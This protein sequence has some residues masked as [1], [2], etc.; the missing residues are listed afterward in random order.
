MQNSLIAQK[1]SCD[2]HGTNKHI[3]VF[4]LKACFGVLWGP[5]QKL[6]YLSQSVRVRMFQFA[7]DF[8]MLTEKIKT[9]IKEKIKFLLRRYTRNFFSECMYLSFFSIQKENRQICQLCILLSKFP[10]IHIYGSNI[11]FH[12]NN[13]IACS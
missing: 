1:I 4:W 12:Q 6:P 3:W 2:V 11:N 9:F 10:G 5:G 8:I 13:F 7:A